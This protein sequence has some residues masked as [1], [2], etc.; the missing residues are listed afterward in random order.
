M[1]LAS[2]VRQHRRLRSN[3]Q[4]QGMNWIRRSTREAIYHRDGDA[5]LYCQRRRHADIFSLSLDHVV[6]YSKGGADSPENL[7]T[8]CLDCNVL[9]SDRSVADFARLLAGP[10]GESVDYLD[11]PSEVIDGKQRLT[12]I[13][14][15]MKDQIPAEL[16]DGTMIWYH[17]TNEV[18][19]RGL[20]S[21]ITYTDISRVERLRFYLKI[22]R[23]GTVHSEAEIGK[24]REML[25]AETAQTPA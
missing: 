18:D 23:G 1:S 24:V 6:P 20:D 8:S 22:N 2:A 16:S 3:G 9:R 10:N 15:W 14:R 12:A 7:V 17:D 21:L 25:A 13:W 5:C 19:R 4:G 11:M